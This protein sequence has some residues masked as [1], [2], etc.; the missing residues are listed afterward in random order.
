MIRINLLPVRAEK[1]RESLRRQLLLGVGLVVL[2]CAGIAMV[3]VMLRSDIADLHVRIAE[4]RAEITR[5]QAIIGEVRE[6]RKKKRELE[7][8]IEI[9]AQ[10]EERQRGPVRVLDALARVI[11]KEIWIE[12]LRDT[13]GA[14]FL[15]GY[16]VDNQTIARFMTSLEDNPWFRGVRLDVTKQVTKGGVSLQ[17][18][19]IRATVAYR[20][21]G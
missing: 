1:K 18:F 6:F 4:R 11:P 7:E 3:H 21:A 19:S 5:L 16:A 10:L 2:L 20:K 8:K 13:G 14:L 12:K 15:E 17:S 9:I